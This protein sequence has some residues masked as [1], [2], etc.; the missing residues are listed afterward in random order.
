[1]SWLLLAVF[2]ALA[3]LSAGLWH[4]QVQRQN[5]QA[6]AAQAASVGASVTTAV[7]RMD[8]LTLAARTLVANEPNL[9]N[10]SFAA[11]YASMGVDKRFK[12]VAGFA[13][14]EI[15]RKPVPGVY[16]SGRRAYYCL[17]RIGVAGPG[18]NDALTDA[19]LPGYDLCQISKLF[20]QTR[21]TGQFS[22]YVTGTG[23]VSRSSRPSIAAAASPRR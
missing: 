12:G 21:D 4:Q 20:V 8:D 22:A 11:W 16:P 23:H 1:M 14:T 5:D 9:T 2:A 7:R 17:P 3:C 6:F 15:V 13:F 19:A 18:M 10:E